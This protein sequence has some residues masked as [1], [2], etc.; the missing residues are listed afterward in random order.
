MT[1]PSATGNGA[2]SRS[3]IK[4][5]LFGAL[6]CLAL[7]AA[8]VLGWDG[9]RSWRSYQ[10][11]VD[12]Q[13][14]DRGINQFVRGLY[15]VLLERLETNSALQAP[16]PAPQAVVA[17]IE[18][19]RKVVRDNFDPGLAAVKQRDFPNN[20]ALLRDLETAR[21]KA[22]EYRR[23]AD[24]ALKLPRDQRDEN[25]RKTFI[26]VITAS[27]NAALDVWSTVLHSSNM[28]DAQL[29]RLA[30]IKDIGW[31]MRDHS[32]QERSIVA[33]A[34]AAGQPIPADRLIVIGTHRAQVA[35]LWKELQHLTADAGT[36]PAIKEAMRSA[37]EKYFKD[38]LA[39]SDSMRKAGE[40]GAK[41]PMTSAQWTETTNPQ[42]GALL[43][44]M[45]AASAA[46][47]SVAETAKSNSFRQLVSALGLILLSFFL[48]AACMWI[49]IRR[50]TQ[51]LT[52]MSKAMHELADGNF[53]VILPGLGRRDEIGDMAQAVESFKLKAVEKAHAET[54]QK[55]VEARAAAAQRKADMQKLADRFEAAIGNIVNT[56]SSASA[57]L[58]AAATTLTRTAENTEQLSTAV[59]S[60]SEE[61][62]ANVQSVASATEEMTGSVNEISRQV[63]ELSKIAREAVTQ[64]ERTD[65]RIVELSQAAGR[66]GDVVKLITSVAE[67]TNLLALNATIE[68]A[69]AGQAGKGFA[70]V[71]SEVKQ[72]ASQT[73]KATEEISAQIA[74]MQH[75]TQELGRR[76]QGDQRHDRPDLRD[77]LDDRGDRGAAGRRDS[78]DRSQRPAGGAGHLAGCRQYRRR[79][80][81]RRGDRLRLRPGPRLGAVALGRGQQ[82]EDRGRSFPRY[83][84]RR[85]TG[86]AALRSVARSRGPPPRR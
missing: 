52:A 44:V 58:E 59:A 6:G 37:Q 60:A 74:S 68:A 86:A 51:P 73:A 36:P 22:N 46:S 21:H 62:S 20:A 53:D 80:P 54:E 50:V 70:V 3:T 84:T 45:Y 66:I 77:R 40:S 35:A 5:I 42:I 41:Y 76:H 75:A 11:A 34:I 14:L 17:K 56:V 9:V 15:E 82:A 63:Q 26:P 71:A 61:A 81:R 28:S 65:A 18:A 2:K 30:T 12:Q 49:V 83:G 85:L 1:I 8:V 4:L 33:A 47:E 32:G 48:A 25:L 39:L 78:R 13:E 38:F 19:F 79:Q 24:A 27:V 23:Q 67:Q 55:D 69:R 64:A 43:D 29:V 10:A 16:D 72:L 57:D 7:L 31:E